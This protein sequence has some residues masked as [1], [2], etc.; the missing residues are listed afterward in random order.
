[1]SDFAI[2]KATFVT[3]LVGGDR[4]PEEQMMEIAMVGR[5]NVGKSSLIN[6]ICNNGKLARTSSTPGKT[7]QINFFNINGG[8]FYLVDLPGYG[9]AKA[10]KTEKATWG[11][12]METYLSSGR[13]T[14]I[15]LLIDIRHEPTQEDKQMFQWIVYYGIPFTVIATKA[16]K[17]AKSK[18]KSEANKMAKLLGAPPFAIPFSAETKVGKEEIIKRIGGILNDITSRLEEEA[19]SQELIEE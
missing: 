14:H 19:D 18:Q 4:P 10:S 5:S 15:F 16:D 3:S 13:L 7:R 17:L 12:L 8:D 11:E 9:F 6:C 1:M 2:K